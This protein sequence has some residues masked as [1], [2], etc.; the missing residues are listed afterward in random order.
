M[1]ETTWTDQE[2]R[3]RLEQMGYDLTDDNGE[4]D[5]G[6]MVEVAS[7]SEGHTYDEEKGVWR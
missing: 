6:L 2:M 3:E 4:Y 7:M 5:V 1:N